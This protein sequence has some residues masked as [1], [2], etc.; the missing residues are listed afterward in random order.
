MEYRVIDLFSKIICKAYIPVK[1]VT[2][3]IA[4][5]LIIIS[6]HQ[7]SHPLRFPLKTMVC[8]TADAHATLPVVYIALV[9]PLKAK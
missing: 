7:A 2:N 4:L 8:I 1:S 6:G 5:Y 9:Y 3:S